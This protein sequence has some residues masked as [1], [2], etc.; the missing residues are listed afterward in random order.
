MSMRR[1]LRLSALIPAATVV[2]ALGLAMASA[3][4]VS[5]TVKGMKFT[6]ADVTVHVGDVIEWTNADPFMHTATAKDGGWDVSL[7]PGKS[8]SVT[9]NKA[10]TVDYF[11]RIHPNMTGKVVVQ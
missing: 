5:V 3:A 10:G 2:F 9:V 11:C 8:G 7:P 4:T 1:N 6:P